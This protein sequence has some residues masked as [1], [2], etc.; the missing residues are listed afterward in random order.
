M[1]FHNLVNTRYFSEAAIEWKKNGGIYTRAPHGSRDYYQYWE[2]QTRRCLYGYKVGDTWITGRHYGYLNFF[3]ISR[4]PEKT[5]LANIEELRDNKGKLSQRISEKIIGF[6]GFWEVDYEWWNFKHIAWY[7]GD[8]MGIHS[9]GGKHMVAL[10]T[11]GCGFSY[12]EAWDGVYNYNFIDGSKSYYFAATEPFLVGDAIMDKVQ[13]GLDWINKYSPFWKKNR[14]VR[15][16]LMHQKASYIDEMG[17]EKGTFSEIIGQI[18]DKPSK[19]RGKRGRKATF[20]EAGSFPNLEAA[21]EVAMGSM[22]EGDAYVGQISVFGTGGEDGPGIQGLEN[23]FNYPDAWDMLSFPNIWEE[24]LAGTECGYFVPCY[25]ANSWFQD[26]DGNVD[27]VAALKNDEVARLKKKKTGKPKDLDRRKAEYPRTP[28]EALSRLN[29][30]GFNLAEIDAQIR[31]VQSN[32]AIQGMLRYGR[33][34][35]SEDVTSNGVKFMVLPKFTAKPIEYYPHL[36]SDDLR[37]CITIAMEPYRDLKGFVPAG[38]YEISIDSYYKEDSEDLTSLFSCKVWKVENGIDPSWTDLPVAWYIG[39][40]GSLDE[41]YEQ[42][43]GLAKYY[44]A[45]IQG[46]IS[47]GG[48][49]VFTY[50]KTY[51]LLDYLQHEPEMVHNKDVAS[52]AAGNA[53]LM[54]MSGDRKK[55]GL[56]YL[57]DWHIAPRGVDESG[58]IVKN[59]HRIYDLGFLYELRKFNPEKG[60]FD[61]ISDA[62]VGMFMLKEKRAAMVQTRRVERTFFNEDRVLFGISSTDIGQLGVTGAW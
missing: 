33:M 20:E 51:R 37:G 8:F 59:I 4:V 49:G 31:R 41:V 19:T 39:R 36:P 38:M 57:E 24:G 42:L 3:P 17:V 12:K 29:G 60:N 53:Y 23:I 26:E 22:R 32:S 25:R 1:S 35:S 27:I 54:N 61:R 2:E 48:M 47:G 40:P 21:V 52:K 55:L 9:D 34:I 5:L 30:N 44:N 15:N 46:E 62:I 10:K 18:V 58:L 50:A 6:P 43:F 16:T 13:A 14:K 56:Q 28:A 45:T 11:R 7:G